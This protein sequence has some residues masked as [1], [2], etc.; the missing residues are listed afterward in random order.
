MP[1][2]PVDPPGAV[3]PDGGS[4][5]PE[6]I[7]VPKGEESPSSQE[8]KTEESKAEPTKDEPT[9]GEQPPATE[10]KEGEEEPDEDLDLDDGEVPVEFDNLLKK[11]KG[12][13]KAAGR[14]FWKAVNDNAQMAK[15]IKQLEEQRTVSPETPPEP[16]SGEEEDV[17]YNI[18]EDIAEVAESINQRVEFLKAFPAQRDKLLNEYGVVENQ[19][20]YHNERVKELTERLKSTDDFDREP[21]QKDLAT[22]ERKLAEFVSRGQLL[23]NLYGTLEKDAKRANEDIKALNRQ[24]AR[25]KK[26]AANAARNQ[27][28]QRIEQAAEDEAWAEKQERRIESE[29]KKLNVPGG[30]DSLGFRYVKAE[31]V[32]ALQRSSLPESG[33]VVDVPRFIAA[34]AKEFVEGSGGKVSPKPTPTPQPPAAQA[35]PGQPGALP[36]KSR[37]EDFEDWSARKREQL[38][39]GPLQAQ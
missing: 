39:R 35:S 32:A 29:L 33:T 21:V 25:L 28:Q 1:L 31:L 24:Q 11:F 15:K 22:H 34:R 18:Q 23:S 26:E 36:P 8:T 13:R 5:L 14:A 7:D 9:K 16:Q 27:E 20:F 6:G 10:S 37:E 19:A 38:A 12:D 4:P 3:V 17:D 30:R 2:F